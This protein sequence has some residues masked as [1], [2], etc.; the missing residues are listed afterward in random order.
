MQLELDPCLGGLLLRQREHRRRAI[1]AD[2]PPAGLLR[3]RHRDPSVSDSEL[4]D[5]PVRLSPA[6]AEEAGVELELHE[7][8]MRDFKV[9]EPAGLVYCPSGRAPPADLEDKRRVFERVS[10]A[11][12][13]G[14]RFVWNASSLT[15]DRGGERR[16]MGRGRGIKH[17][18]DHLPGDNRIDITLESGDKVSLWWVTRSEWEGLIDDPARDRGAYGDFE[19]TP[20]DE[21]SCDSCGWRGNPGRRARTTRSPLYDP[22]SRS[23][24]EDVGFYVKE[25]RQAGGP[26]RA[27]DRHRAGSRSRSPGPG[28]A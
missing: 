18:V 9:D 5:R 12:E 6:K 21:P 27:R 22:W 19:R 28:S 11:L 23:V 16:Q 8:D 14:G 7:G 20:F 4:D 17:R 15:H 13:P 2:D 3:D 1:D 25:A 26:C 24:I 10:A